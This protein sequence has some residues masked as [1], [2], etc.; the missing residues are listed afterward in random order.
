MDAAFEELARDLRTSCRHASGD[1][2]ES[3]L[4]YASV[5]IDEYNAQ[6]KAFIEEKVKLIERFIK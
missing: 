1:I 6:L 5:L 2:E 3:A 4:M